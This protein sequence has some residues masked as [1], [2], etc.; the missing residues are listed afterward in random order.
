MGILA[1]VRQS[2]E[3]RAPARPHFA[4]AGQEVGENE[5]GQRYD[6]GAAREFAD[7][8][9]SG[10]TIG[11][12]HVDVDGSVSRRWA[13]IVTTAEVDGQNRLLCH[14]F[15]S[16][17]LRSFRVDRV[18]N[19]FDEHGETFDV[20]E[21]LLLKVPPTKART[22]G[23]AYRSAVRDGLRVLIAV[24]RA[25]G[26]LD[27]EEV[28]AIMDYARA[29]GARKGVTEDEAALAELR[30]YIERLQPSGSVVAS[31]I[32]RLANEDEQTQ[33]NLLAYLAKVVRADGILDSSEAELE[34]LIAE[35]LE[36]SE[37]SS[38]RGG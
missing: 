16:E 5:I 21:F 8:E 12:E 4:V 32:D 22:G 18:I 14:C 37:I 38:P 17:G 9:L 25:D 23:G 10:M 31:C 35:R 19:L 13:T 11:I 34:R 20:R 33:K 2:F 24:A 15:A 27:A 26:H 6:Y 36:H 30:R 3:G 7:H 28:D 29:E 1:S